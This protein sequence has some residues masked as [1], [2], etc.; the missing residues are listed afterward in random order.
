MEKKSSDNL[1]QAINGEA[2]V[3]KR[4]LNVQVKEKNKQKRENIFHTKCIMLGKVYNFIIDGGS[5]S[6]IAN[7][8]LVKKLGLPTLNHLTPYKLQNDNGEVKVTRQ[9]LV[10]F[11]IGRYQVK[12]L[13]DV[14]LM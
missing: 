9:I 4:V 12:V 7:I 3:V 13:C 1:E 14:V 6:N 5:Y 10:S 2:L 8:V 11:T